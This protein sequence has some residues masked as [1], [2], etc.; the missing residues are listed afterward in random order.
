MEPA[1]FVIAL[2]LFD[3]EVDLERGAISGVGV[4]VGARECRGEPWRRGLHPRVGGVNLHL[5]I[6]LASEGCCRG[7]SHFLR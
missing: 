3:D 4:E 5:P 2:V 7:V 1:G 6:E